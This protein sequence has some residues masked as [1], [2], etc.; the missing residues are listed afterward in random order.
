MQLFISITAVFLAAAI[1]SI[2]TNRSVT[3]WY[4]GLKKPHFTPPNWLFGPV[5]TILYILMAISVFLIWRQGLDTE[6][7][8]LAF[9]LF[10]IQLAFNTMWSVAFFGMRSITGG[11][12]IIS[13]LWM[14]IIATMVTSFAVNLWAGILLVPYII[15]VSL[16]SYLNIGIW[17]E[18][19]SYEK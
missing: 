15:W 12:I 19:R 7:I 17:F 18:N 9:I 8:L 2:F 11:V 16:A 5:W 13:I 10:W 3:N 14:L 1:G 4:A 6:R